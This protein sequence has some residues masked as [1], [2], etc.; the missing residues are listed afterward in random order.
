MLNAMGYNAGSADGAYGPK[1]DTAFQNFAADNN[2]DFV[3][4]LL[5]PA[6]VDNLVN[7]WIESIPQ[8]KWMGQGNRNDPV[9]LV[10][11][12]N[13][14]TGSEDDGPGD[15]TPYS[16]RLTNL[17]TQRCRFDALLLSYGDAP[18]FHSGNLV[19]AVGNMELQRDGGNSVTG[20]FSVAS[21]WGKGKL[22][23]C[24]VGTAVNGDQTWLS[25]V[26]SYDAPSTGD[27]F[28]FF[29]ADEDPN[30]AI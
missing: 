5:R 8:D 20:T 17:G 24:A 23:F 15:V 13:P 25:N 26:R 18:D 9:R 2:L 7:G 12:I 22:S 14:E 6:D 28:I 11:S 3:P 19:M 4:E 30:G 1:L 16:W 21:D 29:G 10:L 27:S